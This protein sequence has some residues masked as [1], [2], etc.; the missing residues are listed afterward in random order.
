MKIK[1]RDGVEIG[2]NCKPFVVAEIGSNWRTFDDC[3]MSIRAAKNCG[4]DA[5]KFQLFDHHALY[6]SGDGFKEA[7]TPILGALPALWLNQL[8]EISDGIG[9]EFM[10]TAFSPELYGVVNPFVNIHKVAS[11]ELTHVRILE[12]LRSFGKP[13]I[14][15]TGASGHEDINNA[16][17][18]LIPV[19]TI[20]MYC[21]AAYPARQVHLGGVA[22]LKNTFGTLV[23]YSDHSIDALVIPNASTAYGACVI[24]KHVTFIDAETPDSP[25]SL[26]ETQFKAMV[27]QIR[28]GEN[29]HPGAT[30]EEKEM[31]TQHNRRLIATHDIERGHELVEGKNFGI[32]RSLKK[33]TKAL[34]PW[35]INEVNGRLAKKA[36]QAG[37]G[38]GPEDV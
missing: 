38:I 34:S 2:D 16:C 27:K 11:A 1:I 24:E 15:S 5:V 26:N 20:L 37:D 29:Y 8:K 18:T 33:D 9:I 19:P 28:G 3:L 23:G 31:V 7:A 21:V 36:I 12:K 25:H 35:C 30:E 22:W 13:V 4:A 14:L 17:K 32:Y 6:G 10:C